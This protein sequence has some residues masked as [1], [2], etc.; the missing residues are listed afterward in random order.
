M[1]DPSNPVQALLSNER[2]PRMARIRQKFDGT[3]LEDPAAE[4]RHQLSR[5]EIKGQIRP[6]MKI[7]ITAGS[8]QL[9]NMVLL[10]RELGRFVRECGA[11]PFIIP[12]M[13]SHGG[14]TAEGQVGILE[15]LG[16]TEATVGMPIRATMET[17]VI[18]ALE[19]GTE[20][21]MDVIA[22]DADGIILINR[23]K[24]HTSFRGK[25]ESGLMKMAVVGLGK[26]YGAEI[27]HH[28]DGMPGM[29][30][31]IELM[32][33]YFMHHTNVLFGV[34]MIENSLD[35]TCELHTLLPEEIIAQEPE[36]L[37][38]ARSLMPSIPLS[39]LDILIVDR[40][41]KNFSGAG[42][43]PNVTHSFGA[44]TKIVSTERAKRIVVF[45]VSDE[46]HGSVLGIGNADIT[47]NRL[48]EK[49]DR[50][51]TYPNLLT[52]GMTAPAKLPVFFDTQELAIKA[53]IKTSLGSDK[54]HL[55]IVRISD[56]L[57][58]GEMWISEALI[59]DAL[60]NSRLELLEDPRPM[61]FDESGNLF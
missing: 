9:S 4:L 31:N 6:G 10:L 20:V 59:P 1:Y 30:K 11:E 51:A 22:R 7:A 50:D 15:S 57:H 24:L 61:A 37:E 35:Q 26:Q 5:P 13:G 12:G 42:M 38:R 23:I 36:L 43:D 32:G 25:Y 45:D 3:Y 39:R 19:D 16:I 46:S 49:M 47:T 2:I 54:E 52:V 41:G 21:R 48:V 58:L 44:E 55:R 8:R 60:A 28:K 34:G 40:I 18:G 56:T 29:S 33:T 17:T 27:V 53:A 14:A